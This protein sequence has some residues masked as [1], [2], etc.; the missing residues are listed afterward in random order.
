MASID[1]SIVE[2]NGVKYAPVSELTPRPSG[3]RAVV[4]VDR[5]WI[6]AGDVEEMD[7]RLILT[8][9]VWVFK[10]ESIGFDGVIKDPKDKRVTLKPMDN[11]VEIPKG[12]EILSVAVHDSWGL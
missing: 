5:G 3:N 12:S 10:W 1:M 9:P 11:P 2:I 8:R 6:F 4:I 7:D